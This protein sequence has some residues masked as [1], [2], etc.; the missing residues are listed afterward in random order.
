MSDRPK[1]RED[2]ARALAER[3]VIWR[4]PEAKEVYDRWAELRDMEAARYQ[5]RA[6][7]LR[8]PLSL[9]S[10]E[11]E[12][13]LALAPFDRVLADLYSRHAMPG[14]FVIDTP[15]PLLSEMRRQVISMDFDRLARRLEEAAADKQN[16]A[17]RAAV[18]REETKA[19]VR[20]EMAALLRV[21]APA[22]KGR[23][24]GRLA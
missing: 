9:R 17:N 10:L 20:D 21:L 23:V 2:A 11:R 16:E 24:E 3:D 18:L 7:R 15:Q 5:R 14:L 4:P 13:R 8:D 12:M 22:I 1:I 19:I 6:E